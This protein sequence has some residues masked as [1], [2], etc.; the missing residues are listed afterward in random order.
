MGRCDGFWGDPYAP[1]LSLRSR[2]ARIG[3]AIMT[4][5]ALLILIICLSVSRRGSASS[6]VTLGDD[7]RFDCTP[8]VRTQVTSKNCMSRGCIYDE[9]VK[10]TVK[11]PRPG[12]LSTPSC[13]YPEKWVNYRVDRVLKKD[14][15][16]ITLILNKTELKDGF[17]NGIETAK[18]DVKVIDDS[19]LEI[20]ITDVMR[21][22]WEPPIPLLNI[23]S[24]KTNPSKLLYDWSLK[25]SVLRVTRK[26]NNALIF[27]TDLR[28]L[29]FSDQFIQIITNVPSN[30]LFGLGDNMDNHLKIFS[31][32][33]KERKVIKLHNYGELPSRG[34]ASYGHH[35]F[36]MMYS[37][38]TG[39]AHGVLLRNV[40]AMDIVLTSTP[41]MTYR[42]T[43]GVLDFFLFLGPTP[44]DVMK[45]KGDLIGHSFL[46]P[47]WSLGFHLCRYGYTNDSDIQEVYERNAGAG[48]P[49]DTQWIDIDYMDDWNMFTRNETAF[50][51]LPEFVK[52]IQSEGRHF[53]PILDPSL[54]GSE[55][56]ESKGF[57][58]FKDGRDKNVFVMNTT[59]QLV[60]GRVWNTKL[61]VFPDFSHPNCSGWWSKHLRNFYKDVKFDGI[62]IDM[63]EPTTFIHGQEGGCVN[64]SLDRPQF[65]PMYPRLLEE[66]TICMSSQHY[67][68]SHYNLHSMYAYFEA[69][70][71]YQALIDI[72]GKRPFILSRAT[73]TGQ[74]SYTAHWLG[75]VTSSWDHLRLAIPQILDY[76]LFGIPFVG[77]DICGFVN[78]TNEELC[79]RWS[80]LGAFFPF[81]RNHNDH[82]TT[83]QDPASPNFG[84]V[85]GKVFEAAKKALDKRYT[86]MPFL[87]T[88]FFKNSMTGNP[89]ARSLKHNYPKE[90]E[91]TSVENS[92]F[93][94]G[95]DLLIN[96]IVEENRTEAEFVFPPG[97]W[98]DMDSKTVVSDSDK[99]T[100]K[101]VYLSLTDIN[102]NF[103][104]GS[105]IPTHDVKNTT[106][107]QRKGLFSLLVFLDK[108]SSASGELF[109]DDGESLN[110]KE[111]EDYS[112]IQFHA[113]GTTLTSHVVF[114]NYTGQAWKD[115]KDNLDNTMRVKEIT[116]YGVEKAP[117]KVT[118][119]TTEVDFNFDEPKQELVIP[120]NG[121]KWSHSLL[122]D[123]KVTWS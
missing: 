35:P 40:N 77:S 1:T 8:D 38:E 113:E 7:K 76:G 74:G 43:G 41:A 100:K 26:A 13:F 58:A 92:Q 55:K 107:E 22:R 44:D 118:V 3:I 81:S 72:R 71:T 9:T 39:D 6:N 62:W 25:D 2:R 102:V 37:N 19:R 65:N 111:W 89:V 82:N 11:E 61:S 70:M 24:V 105:I 101:T 66:L 109:F 85:K 93:M 120:K 57:S 16:G 94:W 34:V 23:P 51:H 75:D 114:G 104:G 78:S 56:I 103:R 84:G 17:E 54:D 59:G 10:E 88:L 119:N 31:S 112:N 69:R 28:R 30:N 49:M 5:M 121:T 60:K 46:P 52:K 47:Y 79:A 4:G 67:L 42:T 32:N 50:E 36:Y 33:T 63:N 21:Q 18:V 98:Y 95:R 15:T 87:Y 106:T 27:E 91:L 108:N 80:S 20:K 115:D 110:T 122:Q 116:I 45:Q 68:T 86:L 48:L 53:V 90:K 117:S 96:P 12:Y 99:V 97:K 123:F 83:D 64:N 14:E 73:V 29:I